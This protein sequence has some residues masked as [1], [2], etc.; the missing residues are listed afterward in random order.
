L[1]EHRIISDDE[2]KDKIVKQQPYGKWVKENMIKFA[3]LPAAES[4]SILTEH[5]TM[6]ERQRI[7]GYS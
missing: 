1:S 6:L 3:D 4:L 2:V 5:K 7:F